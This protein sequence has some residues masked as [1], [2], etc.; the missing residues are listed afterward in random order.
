MRTSLWNHQAALGLHPHPIE[1]I[2]K[3]KWLNEPHHV[4]LQLYANKKYPGL[5]KNAA[6]HSK[7]AT[8]LQQSSLRF[9]KRSYQSDLQ[10]KGATLFFE[11]A[12]YAFL[13]GCLIDMLWP[14]VKSDKVVF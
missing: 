2:A 6:S 10:A 8:R 13:K 9:N 4:L 12:F 7:L 14:V 5:L 1:R 3:S 11:A